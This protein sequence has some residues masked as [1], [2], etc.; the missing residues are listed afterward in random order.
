MPTLCVVISRCVIIS[1]MQFDSDR[2]DRPGSVKVDAVSQ[3]SIPPL[4]HIS[5]NCT[6]NDYQFIKAMQAS[7]N[8]NNFIPLSTLNRASKE[9][10]E[11][12]F[13]NRYKR[14]TKQELNAI[15]E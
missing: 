9:Q 14:P 12:L 6:I 11:K 8:A 1:N 2:G 13:T 5:P 3:L 10:I 7:N 15:Q 4:I